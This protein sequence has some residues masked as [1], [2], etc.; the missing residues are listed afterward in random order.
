MFFPRLR[1]QAKWAFVFLIL[2]FGGGFVFLGVGS[3]GLDLGQLLSDAFGN[4]GGSSGSVSDAQDAVRERPFNAPARRKLA[5]TLEQKGR[6]EEAIAAWAEYVRL[7]PRDIASRRHLGDLQLG[8]ADRFFRQAQLA[9]AAQA[10]ANAGQTFG[11]S[12]SDPFGRALG[13]DPIASALSAKYNAQLQ[14]ASTKYQTA[15]AQAVSTFQGIVKLQPNDQQALF[16]L[17]QAADTLRQT[18]VAINAYTRLLDFDLDEAT[19]SQIR[20]RIKTLRQSLPSQG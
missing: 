6:T 16:S 5:T 9:A 12:Q 10:E 11:P 15:A 14:E 4:R 20:E 17:A 2:V 18:Q 8:Q 3:G 1:N 7:R 19:K 13:Q